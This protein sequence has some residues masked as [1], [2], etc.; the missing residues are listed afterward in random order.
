MKT[1]KRVIL[2]ILTIIAILLIIAYLLPKNWH[3]ERSVSINANKNYIY[4]YTANFGRW[5]LWTP[6][7]KEVDSTVKFEMMGPDGQVGT[8][9]KWDGKTLGNGE[10]KITEQVPG[11]YTGFDVAFNKGQ[12][13]SKGKIIIEQTGDSSKVTWQADGST[14]YNPV[15]RYFGL[16][17][18]HLMGGDFEK[19]LSKLKKVVEGRKN[20]PRIEEKMTGE[21]L[22]LLVRDSAGPTTYPQ[23][24]GKAYGEIMDYTVKNKIKVTG[25]PFA[26]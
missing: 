23:V 1:F 20:W 14:G 11:E 13:K 15:A 16:L 22:V 19:A 26:I 24:M 21:Q 3:V 6:W 2:V 18:D 7:T 5:D 8:T 10:I 9:R 12:F 17:M 4:T 25:K